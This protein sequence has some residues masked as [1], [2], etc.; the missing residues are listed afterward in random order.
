MTLMIVEF[1]PWFA[2]AGA[3]FLLGW[4]AFDIAMAKLRAPG[5]A[6][7]TAGGSG[8][9]L[10]G[11]PEPFAAAGTE[12]ESEPVEV[13]ATTEPEEEPQDAEEAN[14]T[15]NLNAKRERAPSTDDETPETGD[16][17]ESPEIPTSHA[18]DVAES[19]EV[20]D[21]ED[22]TETVPVAESEGASE[23]STSDEDGPVF[24]DAVMVRQD[25]SVR[26]F[27]AVVAPSSRKVRSTEG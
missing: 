1:L 3:A 8:R 16:E 23:D 4:V 7:S 13:E 21:N 27:D 10:V 6:T 15:A 19:P 11:D 12:P 25:P 20:S 17:T 18:Q 14:E 26:V 5:P 24:A 9:G 22:D 2:F